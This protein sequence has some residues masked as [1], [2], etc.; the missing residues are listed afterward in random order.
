MICVYHVPESPQP[1]LA[2][3]VYVGIRSVHVRLEC[4]SAVIC[5][6]G[7]RMQAICCLPCTYVCNQC[8][9]T[10]VNVSSFTV[11]FFPLGKA[12]MEAVVLKD[13]TPYNYISDDLLSLRVGEVL[14]NVRKVD[15]NWA[16]GELLG[17]MGFF[18]SNFVKMREAVPEEH[19]PPPSPP[20]PPTSEEC[21]ERWLLR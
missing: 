16:E 5:N 13:Y 20:P 11:S 4:P 19:P 15:E 14:K 17:I 3:G 7:Q 9:S 10:H 6:L 21:C 1:L 12:P 2:G 8:S 18:P